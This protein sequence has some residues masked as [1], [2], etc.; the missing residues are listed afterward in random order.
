M[1]FHYILDKMEVGRSSFVFLQIIVDGL[2]DITQ[3][4]TGLFIVDNNFAYLYNS[5]WR[6]HL[7]FDFMQDTSLWDGTIKTQFNFLGG[8]A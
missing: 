1:T 4:G 2:Y 6:L 8:P 5:I 3:Q 7:F